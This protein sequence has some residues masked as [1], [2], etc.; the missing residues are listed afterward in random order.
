MSIGTSSSVQ[1]QQERLD[2]LYADIQQLDKK[3]QEI[4]IRLKPIRIR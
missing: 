2:A 1:F 4:P 3:E